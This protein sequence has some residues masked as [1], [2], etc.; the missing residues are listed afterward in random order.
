MLWHIGDASTLM[1]L[2]IQP[3]RFLAEREA[4]NAGAVSPAAKPYVAVAG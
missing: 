1:Q 2:T 3:Q 4:E